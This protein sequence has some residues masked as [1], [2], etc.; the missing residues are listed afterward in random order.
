MIKVLYYQGSNFLSSCLWHFWRNQSYGECAW[1]LTPC[2]PKR[3]YDIYLFENA[4]TCAF[5][6]R[7]TRLNTRHASSSCWFN[8]FCL[9]I[10]G[11]VFLKSNHFCRPLGRKI[12]SFKSLEQRSTYLFSSYP[13]IMS[14][15]THIALKSKV[16]TVQMITTLHVTLHESNQIKKSLNLHNLILRPV[17]MV[18]IY[19]LYNI[20]EREPRFE[21]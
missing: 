8:L 2:S 7:Q 20:S 1:W 9:I 6:N 5:F 11:V 17:K 15:K 16:S 12:I 13:V 18:M 10:W 3:S 14:R 4:Y 19:P 21:I